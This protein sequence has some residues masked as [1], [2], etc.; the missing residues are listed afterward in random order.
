MRVYLLEEKK[1]DKLYY[2]YA[3]VRE[4]KYYLDNDELK[5]DSSFSIP[6]K[7]VVEKTNDQYLVTDSRIPR[8]GSYYSEDM[9]NIFPISVRRDMD[10]VHSDG[11]VVRLGMEIEE[12]AKLYFHK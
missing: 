7:F 3:W 2:I 5:E 10:K 1:R 4:S 6:H 12:Q 9:K 11:T 8:D